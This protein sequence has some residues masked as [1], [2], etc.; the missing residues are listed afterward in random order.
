MQGFIYSANVQ[1]HIGAYFYQAFQLVIS[2]NRKAD[3]EVL[4]RRTQCTASN[5]ASKNS[6]NEH[7]SNDSEGPL[8]VIADAVARLRIRRW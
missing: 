1:V 4:K 2:T 3:M 8:M 5:L 7:I 6:L